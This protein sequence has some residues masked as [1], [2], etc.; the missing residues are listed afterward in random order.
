MKNGCSMNA[1]Y[2]I[3]LDDA[4]PTMD[5][6]K[7]DKMEV[8]L[9][10]YG[11][12]PIVAVIPN[13]EDEK[14]Y[15]DTFDDNF[16]DRVKKWQNKEWNIALHGYNHVYTTK[17]SGLVPFNNRSEFAGLDLNNQEEKIKK[18]MEVFNRENIK[19]DIWVAPSHSF[20]KVTLN[21]LKKHTD[22]SIIS[23]GIAL[24]PYK[25]YGFNWIPQQMWRFRN[26]PLGTWTVCFHP[27]EMS[28]NEFYV[29]KKFIEKNYK[30]FININNLKYKKFCILNNLFSFIYWKIKKFKK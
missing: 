14:L 20:D 21:V 5:T 16:W 7:W 28:E 30:N 11:I 24:F 26:M 8:L 17:N 2:I 25:K 6:D 19:T 10:T 13:N 12:K 15:K 1:K 4:C 18:S 3:R 29:L 27:N 23:D 22:I 9:D